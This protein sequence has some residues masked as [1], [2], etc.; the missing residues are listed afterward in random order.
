MP[1]QWM[2]V[3][4]SIRLWTRMRA[5]SPSR[6]RRVGP[7]LTPLMVMPSAGF[8]VMLTACRAMVRSYSTVAPWRSGGA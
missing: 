1:C 3:S 2:D 7:G 4:S 8:P 6:K 5:R